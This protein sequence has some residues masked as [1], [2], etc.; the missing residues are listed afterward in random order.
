LNVLS[1]LIR[2]TVGSANTVLCEFVRRTEQK[3]I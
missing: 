3:V 2:K 1:A